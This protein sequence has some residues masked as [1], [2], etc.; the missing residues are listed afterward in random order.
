M[1][2]LALA[3]FSFELLNPHLPEATVDTLVALGH[4]FHFE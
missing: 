4:R 3:A 2:T 1:A